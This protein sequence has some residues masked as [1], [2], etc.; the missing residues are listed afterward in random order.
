MA[1]T[2]GVAGKASKKQAAKP[3]AKG[4]VKAAKNA[5]SANE[6]GTTKDAKPAGA[7]EPRFNLFQLNGQYMAF[8]SI[9]A[10]QSEVERVRR[11][12]YASLMKMA[13]G[14]VRLAIAGNY[15]AAKFLCEFAGI[16]DLPPVSQ[17]TP[18]PSEAAAAPAGEKTAGGAEQPAPGGNAV[19]SF[20]NRLGMQPPVFKDEPGDAVDATATV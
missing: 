3:G 17:V 7:D 9:A 18:E 12:I 16:D 11:A 10:R 19:L 20:Y 13:L 5:G 2:K 4:F 8:A 15:S 14:N 1:G 6:G